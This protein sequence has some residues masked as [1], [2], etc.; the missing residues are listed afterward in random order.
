MSLK[1]CLLSLFLIGCASSAP[2]SETLTYYNDKLTDEE[3]TV[4][5]IH[6]SLYWDGAK[7]IVKSNFESEAKSDPDYIEFTRSNVKNA[8]IGLFGWSMMQKNFA[9]SISTGFPFVLSS[10]FTFRLPYDIYSTNRASLGGGYET[11]LQKPVYKTNWMS[12]NLG[13]AYRTD[14]YFYQYEFDRNIDC[15]T[16]YCLETGT[17]SS[18]EITSIHGP[19]V[20]IASPL[21]YMF[22][23]YGAFSNLNKPVFFITLSTSLKY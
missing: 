9:F 14:N 17:R 2:M 3:P 7:Y 10:D 13:Y 6:Y 21:F 1:P 5:Q 15:V 18:T 20:S 8:H 23:H 16:Y 19:R 12:L 11:I 22:A 4:N